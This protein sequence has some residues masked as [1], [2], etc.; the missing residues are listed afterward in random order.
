MT[1]VQTCALPIYSPFLILDEPS[2]ELDMATEALVIDIARNESR[3]R[4][5]LII[6]HRETMLRAC[7]SVVGMPAARMMAS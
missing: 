3:R 1:G 4:G 7:D 5:I 6:S 2:A